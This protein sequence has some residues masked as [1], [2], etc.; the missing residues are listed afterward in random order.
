MSLG[1]KS[2]GVIASYT[3]DRRRKN[4]TEHRTHPRLTGNANTAAMSL[5]RMPHNR[6]PQPR[7]FNKPALICTIKA[8][9]HKRQ[10][11]LNNPH[12]VVFYTDNRRTVGL[13]RGR[14]FYLH[15]RGG[16]IFQGVFQQI[17]N[18]L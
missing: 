12:T 15:T 4:N 13:T 11:L 18:N 3:K 16:I 2:I 7:T 9:E 10:S 6:K 8:I 14:D 17:K 1:G 5:H